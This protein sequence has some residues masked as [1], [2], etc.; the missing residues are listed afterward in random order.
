MIKLDIPG[1]DKIYEYNMPI[2]ASS[3]W[4][5]GTKMTH[6]Q[7]NIEPLWPTILFFPDLVPKRVSF[8]FENKPE[9]KMISV[10][11]NNEIRPELANFYLET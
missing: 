5:N 10:L 4:L 7:S 1:K 11:I 2:I 9:K 6:Y 3:G 8:K